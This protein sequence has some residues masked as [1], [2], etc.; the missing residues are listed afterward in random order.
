MQLQ[1][2]P[3]EFLCLRSLGAHRS[4]DARF[5]SNEIRASTMPILNVL[6]LFLLLLGL[7]LD[8]F[9]SHII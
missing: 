9:T 5:I 7:R 1:C 6:C 3:L 8:L 2:I 4:D